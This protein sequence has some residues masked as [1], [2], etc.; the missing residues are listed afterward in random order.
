GA[1][2]DHGA[3]HA[4][5]HRRRRLAD[6]LADHLAL[7]LLDDRE[8]VERVA[9]AEKH[10]IGLLPAE[11]AHELVHARQADV[12]RDEEA[13]AAQGRQHANAERQLL[14]EGARAV[15]LVAGSVAPAQARVL[16]GRDDAVDADVEAA[17]ALAVDRNVERPLDDRADVEVLHHADRRL[18]ADAD[19]E[20]IGAV[21]LQRVALDARDEVPVLLAVAGAARVLR[22]RARI[23]QRAI[24]SLLDTG[25]ERLRVIEPV[26]QIQARDEGDAVARQLAQIGGRVG[27]QTDARAV[28]DEA[29][30]AHGIEQAEAEIAADVEP[31]E[32]AIAAFDAE[33][34]V[35]EHLEELR[36]LLRIAVRPAR[37]RR[38]E[39]EELPG[40]P[41][42]RERSADVAVIARDARRGGSG[43]RE[44][45]VREEEVD[46]ELRAECAGRA[47]ARVDDVNAARRPLPGVV[48]E[49]ATL[50]V[51]VRGVLVVLRRGA[52]PVGL[53]R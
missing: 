22:A 30:V 1:L 4:A 5:R 16:A 50:A 6:H 45:A 44:P 28:A 3:D 40:V 18:E 26:L 35:A 21:D 11:L 42:H 25:D 36:V 13:Q 48:D 32:R 39:L 51:R 2:L 24:A 43:Q 15:E 12:D 7:D 47:A 49:V 9:E 20:A 38:V 29:D 53:G 10:V 23:G 8:G 33:Q 52:P 17:E 41:A 14:L 46:A 27:P 37:D 19:G 31:G 34:G